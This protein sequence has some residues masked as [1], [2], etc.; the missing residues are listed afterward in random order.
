V[1]SEEEIGG[2]TSARLATEPSLLGR[3]YDGQ[4]LEAMEKHIA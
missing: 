2:W 1:E 4:F 3:P